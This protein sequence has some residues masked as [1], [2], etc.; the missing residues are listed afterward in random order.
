V[1]QWLVVAVL[2]LVGAAAGPSPAPTTRPALVAKGPA[3]AEL[4]N[5]RFATQ[6][7][8]LMTQYCFTCHGNGKHKGD[9]TLDKYAT[10]KDV[11]ADKQTWTTVMDVLSQ[12]IMPPEEKPQPAKKDKELIAAWAAEAMDYI[13][14]S[15]PR[16]PGHV[17]LHRLNRN[18][19]NNTIRDLCAIDFKP[20]DDFPA[21]DTGYGF[22]NIGDVLSMSPL[23]AEKYLSAA[24]QVMERAI[25]MGNP[26]AKKVKRFTGIQMEPT[27]G[28]TAD[29]SAW[30]L[31]NNGELFKKF[32]FVT[33]AEYEIRIQAFGEQ[34]GEEAP[35]MVL[36]LDG[37][38]ILTFDV[39]AV[40]R[41][42]ETY[43]YRGKIPGGNHRVALAYTNN[44]VDRNNPD[45]SKR[46][47]R[48]LIVVWMEIEGPF[49]APPPPIPESHKRVLVATPGRDGTE[50]ECAAKIV[51]NFATRAFRRPASVEE[52]AG[53][54]RLYRMARANKEPFEQAVKIPLQAVL[55]SPHFL[56]RVETDPPA[57][58][59]IPH[60]ISD[61]ELA[62]RLSYF[63]WSSMPDDE[64]MQLAANRTLH[65]PPVLS[66]QVRR[67]LSDPRAVE[68]VRNFV[69]QW[70]ELRN[71]DDWTPDERRFPNFDE[72][73]R[74]AMK[75]EAELFFSTVIKE[76]RSILELLDSD[77]TYVN[78]RL[79]KH[80]GMTDVKGEDF[81][82]VSLAGTHRGGV[83][84]MASVLTVTAMP[85]RTS[86]VKRGKFVLEQILGTP[87]P[88]PPP[89][90]PA[91][92]DKRED[93]QAASLRQRL[94]KHRS[95]PNCAVCHQRMD[96]IGFAMENFDAIGAWRD[97]DAG[98]HAIDTSG[99][100]PNGQV[101]DGPEN[102]R[103][104][105]VSRK[106]DFLRC[107]TEKMLTYA[108]GRGM[109]EYDRCTVKEICLSVEKNNYRFSSVVDAIVQSDAFLKRRGKSEATALVK[110]EGTEVKK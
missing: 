4:L 18:E 78:E 106:G 29:S 22:D 84:T 110:V 52:V 85:S 50:D 69:G 43:R 31:S 40:G 51:R 58:P 38:D 46:G 101:V 33:A 59:E 86:P 8:P 9:V 66:K 17:T 28:Q 12:G 89:E 107:V 15:G 90:V 25:L 35:K 96:P 100:L 99:K 72:K 57:N 55:V 104:V 26:Y 42:P 19:Y 81:K 47:D 105:L 67:M 44:A 82:R 2:G 62:S 32:D 39:K 36:R 73:L 92:P 93:V 71:L 7:K 27:V 3:A 97:K 30:N 80:Y 76:D 70:L 24:E 60:P 20:A 95:N 91:L 102:L 56:F 1:Y 34:F 11:Q 5:Q 74:R 65:N 49:N 14:C 68:L 23:L 41:F 77:Y 6:I 87:P 64:L 75:K 16:D 10:W 88:P 79:A 37:K 108:L 48:N 83:L 63:I 53:L 61:Y 54:M 109:E 103:K 13:D 21:D 45:R 98:G 94:E